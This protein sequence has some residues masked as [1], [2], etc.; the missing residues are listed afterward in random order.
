MKDWKNILVWADQQD[1]VEQQREQK[2]VR[3]EWVII[4]SLT[5]LF[6]GI[7]V[8]SLGLRSG[9]VAAVLVLLAVIS[10]LEMRR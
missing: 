3:K 1:Q 7:A 6:G 10:T 5:A 8:L 9:G 2:K 4:V